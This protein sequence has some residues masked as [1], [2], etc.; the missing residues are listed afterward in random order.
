MNSIT[1]GALACLL[2]AVVLATAGCDD[3]SDAVPAMP[4]GCAYDLDRWPVHPTGCYETNGWPTI[5]GDAR[6]S[7]TSP[8]PGFTHLE[9]LWTRALAG[10]IAAAATI[11]SEGQVYVTTTGDSSD[12]GCHLFAIDLATG[13]DRWCS[14]QVNEW[15]VGSSVL[16][17]IEGNLF[18]GDDEAMHSFDR[19][20]NL[21]WETPTV[22]AAISAQ[23]LLN[24]HLIFVT[25]IGQ[26]MVLDRNSGQLVVPVYEML[27]GQTYLP[28]TGLRDCLFGGPTCPSANT[29][30]VDLASGRFFNTLRQPGAPAAALQGLQYHYETNHISPLWSNDTLGGGT[31]SSPVISADGARLYVN[32]NEGN[33]H[34]LDAATG[35]S[36]WTVDIGFAAGGSASVN[37]A[38]R[39]LPAGSADSRLLAVQ[40]N[41]ATGSIL[42]SNEALVNLGIP[43]Q[44]ANDIVYAFV[45]QPG[46]ALGVDF[47]SV[48]GSTGVVNH[49]ITLS[50]S[51][52]FTLGTSVAA[53]G[54]VLVVG[55]TGVVSAFKPVIP[56]GQ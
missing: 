21:R 17:D 30:S 50:P 23:F 52:I 7:D 45:R 35:N 49:R 42:W 51:P 29:L 28:G 22:G 1:V 18:V 11:D 39:S 54:T 15:A 53:D 3:G 24:G 14:S 6:N 13:A 48:N 19:D 43:V 40:D 55:L 10:N 16:I 12:D 2:G 36:I 38:G 37:A 46:T 20:G 41:G 32:D 26:V 44:V 8:A 4:T 9:A 47:V 34:A 33:Y 5:H 27:P 31:A 56:P 25:H